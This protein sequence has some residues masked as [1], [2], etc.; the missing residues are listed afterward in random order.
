MTG[1]E[2]SGTNLV[3]TAASSWVSIFLLSSFPELRTSNSQ[4]TGLVRVIELEVEFL[5]VAAKIP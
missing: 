4:P 1:F 2:P 5:G 3:M